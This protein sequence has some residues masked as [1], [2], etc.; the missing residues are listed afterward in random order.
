MSDRARAFAAKIEWQ[1]K[2]AMFPGEDPFEFEILYVQLAEEYTPDGPIEEDL[3][4]TVA[5]LIRR[6]WRYQHF[7][8]ARAL[9]ARLDC[10]HP[11]F[12]E[13]LAL[14]AFCDAI[15]GLTQDREVDRALQGLGAYLA[16]H[17]NTKRPREDFRST[18]AWISALKKEVEQVLLPSATRFGTKP[19]DVLMLEASTI[20]TDDLFARE[21]EFEERIDRMIERTLDRLAKEKAAD[22]Q[23]SFRDS[24]RFNR[25]R[26]I[27]ITGRKNGKPS[28]T[29]PTARPQ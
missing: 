21:L 20:L 18:K 24:H 8:A 29:P 25:T 16:G 19:L 23:R 27:R 3:V 22:R 12:D 1:T 11:A 2:F 6:K 5:K 9:A 7:S 14:I 15:E 10:S 28:A 13:M 26:S 17:L 4:F